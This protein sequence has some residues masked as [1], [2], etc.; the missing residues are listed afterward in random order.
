MTKLLILTLMSFS[1]NSFA[2]GL[3]QADKLSII[4][5]IAKSERRELWVRG[6]ENVDSNIELMSKDFLLEYENENEHYEQPLDGPE[7]EELF[8]C[9]EN[10]KCELY[11]IGLSSEFYSGY[12]TDSI[13][14]LL[15]KETGNIF[16][17]I[18]HNTYSE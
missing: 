8:S 4:E 12:G 3:S 7:Y 11:L 15:S 16:N 6:H 17:T 2:Q 10:T 5:D 1:L 14:V 13:F 18:K 9:I